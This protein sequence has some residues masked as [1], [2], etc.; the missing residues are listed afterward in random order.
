MELEE[1]ILN[2]YKIKTNL[3]LYPGIDNVDGI[4][5]SERNSY[6]VN[7]L[8]DNVSISLGEDVVKGFGNYK[9]QMF[10]LAPNN[11]SCI[12]RIS[13]FFNILKFKFDS[14]KN[15]L[16]EYCPSC[17]Q[18]AVHKKNDTDYQC[19]NCRSIWSYSSCPNCSH[20]YLYLRLEDDNYMD[21]DDFDN[22]QSYL[23][24]LEIYRGT[25]ALTNI[26]IENEYKTLC[27]KCGHS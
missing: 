18:K 27:P 25:L 26:D 13:R 3:I 15:S 6:L 11:L 17:G 12:N 7:T 2:L 24:Y 4:E 23:N 8:G 22:L 9:F 10:E 21:K 19:Y 20:D 16:E 1:A 14:Y 5:V